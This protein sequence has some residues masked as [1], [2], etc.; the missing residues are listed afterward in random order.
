MAEQRQSNNQRIQVG[1]IGLVIVL[2]FVSLTNMAID[3]ASDST[4]SEAHSGA[5]PAGTVGGPQSEV[6]DEPLAE[7]GVTPVAPEAKNE[8]KKNAPPATGN[9]ST[10]RPAPR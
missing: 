5:L 10:A 2:L 6:K 8:G 9:V 7:L 3:G 4:A 1:I